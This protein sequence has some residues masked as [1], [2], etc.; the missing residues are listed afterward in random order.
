[1]APVLVRGQAEPEQIESRVTE[2]LDRHMDV[3]SVMSVRPLAEIRA[4]ATERDRARA[5]ITALFGSLVVVMAGFGFFA[6]QRFLVDSGQRE[7]AVRMAL[8]AGPRSVRRRIL[9]RGLLLGLPGTLLGA[10]LGLV[11]VAW[12]RDD[13]IS[14]AVNAPGVAVLTLFGL[15]VLLLVATIQPA[16]RAARLHPGDLLREE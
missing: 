9:Q 6:M 11:A 10:L 7:I 8:G 14:L 12:L 16:L 5:G 3:L 1:M 15:T 2:A 13:L 4:E